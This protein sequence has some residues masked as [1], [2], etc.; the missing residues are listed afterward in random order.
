[1]KINE[2]ALDLGIVLAIVSSFK[3]RPIDEKTICFGEIGLSGEVRA[4]SQAEQRVL[5][6]KKLGYETVV[7]PKVSM[8]GLD[9]IQGIRMIGISGIGEAID[10]I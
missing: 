7:L 4:V 1:M 6:A 10:L 9:P 2:P 3:N 5:E 8:E